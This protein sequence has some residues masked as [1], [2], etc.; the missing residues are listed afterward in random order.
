MYFS[1]EIIETGRDTLKDNARTFNT[2]SKRFREKE[3]VREYLK[4]RYGRMP[5]KRNK[6]Y[7]DD[8]E[9]NPVEIG[10][11]YSYWNKDCSHDTKS[12]YQT[13]WISLEKVLT[14]PTSI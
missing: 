7:M 12:W 4:E 11:T 13:D 9:G 6:V 14:C 10:F 1:L 5:S 2:I 3:E 8:K